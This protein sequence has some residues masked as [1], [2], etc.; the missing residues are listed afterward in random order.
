ML[1][2]LGS[3]ARI[4]K[5]G[6]QLFLKIIS[7]PT[8]DEFMDGRSI[9][10]DIS[11]AYNAMAAIYTASKVYTKHRLRRFERRSKKFSEYDDYLQEILQILQIEGYEAIADWNYLSPAERNFLEGYIVE[12]ANS[13]EQLQEQVSEELRAIRSA[14]LSEKE[15]TERLKEIFKMAEARAKAIAR[16]ETTRSANIGIIIG[17]YESS[18]VKAYEFIAVLD[19]RTT[20]I[21]ESRHGMIFRPEDIDLLATNTPPLHVNCRSVL[22]VITEYTPLEKPYT[23]SEDLQKLHETDSE[24]IPQQ[25]NTDI[26]KLRDLL[27]SMRR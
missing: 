14:G 26:E 15:A 1:I 7:F 18:I 4:Y 22:N 3:V 2:P 25:R 23:T 8:V 12:L 16:T 13:T 20:R 11:R 17:S 6:F 27:A 24:T 10:I 5:R 21:C 9:G 19:K